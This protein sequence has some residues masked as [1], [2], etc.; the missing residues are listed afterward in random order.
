MK[1]R[2]EA[3]LTASDQTLKLP[4]DASSLTIE[5]NMTSEIS[6]FQRT[7][8]DL[9]S[10]HKVDLPAIASHSTERSQNEG[11]SKWSKVVP[12]EE[13]SLKSLKILKSMTDLD[14]MLDSQRGDLADEPEI[15]EVTH[16]E[17]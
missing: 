13:T 2:Q 12:S 3:D 11:P 10:Q 15:Q 8:V 7:V 9:T 5:A 6:N 17:K 1:S 16:F 14:A 4:E